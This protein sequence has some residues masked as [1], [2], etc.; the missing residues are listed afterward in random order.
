M[1]WSDEKKKKGWKPFSYKDN[2]IQD[3]QGNEEKR[4]PV[5]DSNKTKI[6]DTKEPSDFL[7]EKILQRITEN[8]M[9]MI[10]EWITKIYKRHSR[11]FKTPKIKKERRRRNK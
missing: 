7:K 3:S 6:N 8:L 9:E 5:L 11:N 2:L 1:K 4:Y 10:L